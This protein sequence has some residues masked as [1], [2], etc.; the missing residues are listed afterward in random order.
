MSLLVEPIDCTPNLPQAQSDLPGTVTAIEIGSHNRSSSA[1]RSRSVV[2]LHLVTRAEVNVIVAVEA[3]EFVEQPIRDIICV[4][5]NYIIDERLILAR[6][7]FGE[8]F[9]DGM[10]WMRSMRWLATILFVCLVLFL[11]LCFLVFFF[12]AFSIFTES[13]V[14]AEIFCWILLPLAFWQ[15]L[16]GS[17]RLVTS[18][19]LLGMRTWDVFY[20]SVQNM[21]FLCSICYIY[22]D[23][24]LLLCFWCEGGLIVATAHFYFY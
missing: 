10:I 20:F 8:R 4:E 21:G 3:S 7:F 11:L 9:A 14:R 18:V 23:Q 12:T 1:I 13:V 17:L 5:A 2:P 6:S 22:Q 16:Q 24:R 19:V 15:L